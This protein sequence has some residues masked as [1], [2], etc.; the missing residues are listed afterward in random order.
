[1]ASQKPD[2]AQTNSSVPEQE[3][4]PGQTSEKLPLWIPAPKVVQLDSLWAMLP[5]RAQESELRKRTGPC[6]GT[7]TSHGPQVGVSSLEPLAFRTLV[8]KEATK[9]WRGWVDGGGEEH[10]ATTSNGQYP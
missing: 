2:H 5:R 7:S 3:K 6:S 4:E 10:G 8:M 1:M 9:P